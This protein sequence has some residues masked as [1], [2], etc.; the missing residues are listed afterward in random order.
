MQ[1]YPGLPPP[2]PPPTLPARPVLGSEPLEGGI[3]A[4][5]AQG[6]LIGE[7][8]SPTKKRLTALRRQQISPALDDFLLPRDI[9]ESY[10]Q[11]LYRLNHTAIPPSGHS[12]LFKPFISSVNG[13]RH[14]RLCGY[15]QVNHTQMI[16]H[17]R[18]HFGVYPFACTVPGW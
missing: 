18:D 14:C 17:I 13:E 9:S 11:T 16:Q 12:E 6:D 10:E 1:Y 5:E 2:P 3:H 7:T 15:T 8:N 4:H